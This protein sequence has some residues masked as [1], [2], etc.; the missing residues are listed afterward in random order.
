MSE[1]VT[2]PTTT[3]LGLK[4]PGYTN[5]ADIKDA[6][7]DNMDILDSAFG[8][9]VPNGILDK[10][11]PIGSIYMSVVDTNPSTLFGGTWTALGGRFLIGA[12]STYSAG[13]TGG[14][15]TKTLAAGNIP[16]HSHSLNSHVHS[17]GAHSHGL[18]GHTHSYNAP[19]NHTHGLSSGGALIGGDIGEELRMKTKHFENWRANSQIQDC[20]IDGDVRPY[21]QDGVE[22]TGTTDSGGGS[23][24]STTGGA[25]GNTAN[26]SAFNT[27]A[28][29]GNT[30][31]T[32]S[33]S[34]FN[35]MPPYLSVY[36][37]KRTA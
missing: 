7:D 19:A 3:N 4:K 1:E 27:G 23:T 10:V 2:I 9:A 8:V 5:F 32:G 37:W 15:A 26:S 6:V 36:M 24:S 33:G 16:S 22:L 31:A 34:A 25:S 20:R 13:A 14:S 12:D 30:G 18:N 29:S 35:I 21:M 11:Y 28:A 17:V